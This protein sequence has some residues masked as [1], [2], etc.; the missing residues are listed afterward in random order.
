MTSMAELD[1]LIAAGWGDTPSRKIPADW[2]TKAP[3]TP[4]RSSAH[5]ALHAPTD[6]R[7]ARRRRRSPLA[8]ERRSA[9]PEKASA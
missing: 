3:P 6:R 4:R 9:G 1:A 7:R 5:E 2:R 8:P